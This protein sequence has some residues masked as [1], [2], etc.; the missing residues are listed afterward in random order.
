MGQRGLKSSLCSFQTIAAFI[1][2]K[3]ILDEVKVVASKLQK[4]DQDILDALKMID[5]V[6]ESIEITRRNI[7]EIFSKWYEDILKLADMVGSS[8]SIPKEDQSSKEPQ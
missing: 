7:D 6:I 8:A 5:S 1:V 2:T 4:G 3:N